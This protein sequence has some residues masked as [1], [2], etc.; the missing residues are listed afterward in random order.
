MKPTIRRY[1]ERRWIVRW[2]EESSGRKATFLS[3]ADAREFL[4]W[5]YE[6]NHVVRYA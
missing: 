5:L 1:K 3:F 2:S 4:A 6:N